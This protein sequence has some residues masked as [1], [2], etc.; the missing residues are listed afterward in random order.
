MRPTAETVSKRLSWVLPLLAAA[1]GDPAAPEPA[2]IAISPGTVSLQALGETVQLTATVE[3]SAEGAAS[4]SEV[5]VE[6]RTVRVRV[7]PDDV[8]LLARGDTMRLGV[9]AADANGHP[10]ED[11]EITWSPDD[12]SVVTVDATG[13]VTALQRGHGRL[14]G[15]TPPE[16]GNLGDLKQ[17]ELGDNLRSPG[18]KRIFAHPLTR[19]LRSG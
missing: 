4:R 12:E 8:T 9:D 11:A 15:R 13:L 3:A 6:Q 16:L 14:S 7:S 10:V 17:L 2:T 5:T 18:T 19:S 1:C